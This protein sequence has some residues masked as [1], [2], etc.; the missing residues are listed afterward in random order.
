MLSGAQ[1]SFL[2]EHLRLHDPVSYN[3]YM[4]N[5]GIDLDLSTRKQSILRW[6]RVAISDSFLAKLREFD[7]NPSNYSGYIHPYL[8]DSSSSSSLTESDIAQPET[9]EAA[10]SDVPSLT[11]SNGS[12]EE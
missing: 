5:S 6:K 3:L 4:D 1:R 8:K 11:S 12:P 9:T 10:A 2:L 7:S